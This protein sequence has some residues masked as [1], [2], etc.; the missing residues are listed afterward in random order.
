[1]VALSLLP[2]A[3]KNSRGMSQIDL[4]LVVILADSSIFILDVRHFSLH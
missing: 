2:G 4:G 1:M 3:A